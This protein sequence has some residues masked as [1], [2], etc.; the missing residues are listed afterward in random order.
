MTRVRLEIDHIVI[1][2]PK[3]RWRLYFIVVTEHPS[4]PEKMV[5]SMIPQNSI[6]VVPDQQ[7]TVYFESEGNGTNGLHVLTRPIPE[8]REL[9]V[10]V[11]VMHSRR[12]LKEIGTI[13]EDIE[14][15]VGGQ[16]LGLVADILG[17][18]A[19]WLAI[20]RRALPLIGQVIEKIPD[21]NMGFISMF[22]RFG[23]EFRNQVELD[24]EARGGNVSVVYSWS[25]NR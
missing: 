1:H 6:L 8:D 9:N 22:E 18:T 5:V 11:Y 21:R 10:H 24:R 3:K 12:S 16:A 25:V 23:S 7:N 15:G 13:L 19:P 17:T 2:R 4:D 14:K 20:A